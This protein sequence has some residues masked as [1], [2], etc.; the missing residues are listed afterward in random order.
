MMWKLSTR[1]L[2]R[3]ITVLAAA[4]AITTTN[5]AAQGP[6]H[7]ELATAGARIDPSDLRAALKDFTAAAQPRF[8]ARHV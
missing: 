3:A 4:G 5:A 1:T 2:V 8:S 6:M 7:T